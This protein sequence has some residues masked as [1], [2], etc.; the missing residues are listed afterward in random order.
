MVGRARSGIQHTRSHKVFASVGQRCLHRR[1]AGLMDAYVQQNAV[2]GNRH[3]VTLVAPGS[4][5]SLARP[6]TVVLLFPD[7]FFSEVIALLERLLNREVIVPILIV[8]ST[9]FVKQNGCLGK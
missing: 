7:L 6:I 5:I 3:G 9:K 4:P 2:G 1:G 8:G